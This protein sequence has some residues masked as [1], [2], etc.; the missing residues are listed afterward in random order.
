MEFTKSHGAGNDFVL[1][2][3]FDDRLGLL[4]PKLVA[5]LCD[6]HQG[7]GAD[8]LIRIAP[9]TTSDFFMDYYNADGG[10][11]EMCGNGIRCLAKFVSDR[12][13]ATGDRM[14]VDTRAGVKDLVLYRG[15][16]GLVDRVRV[17]MGAPILERDRIPVAG[18]GD[19]LHVMVEAGGERFEAACVSMGN[20]HAV[21]FVD[22]LQ[23][24]PVD[25]LG[26]AIETAPPFPAKTNVEFTEV[27]SPD[28]V[29]VRVWERGVGETR[30]LTGRTVA[31]HMPGGTLDIEWS[32]ETVFLTGPVVEAF[33]G[34]FDETAV[35]P[36]AV[37]R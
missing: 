33:R 13:L 6:R 15:A 11:A 35:L 16:D 32:D 36:S 37:R 8:G 17:D 26:P 19:P 7:V 34:T 31:V 30:G 20:P 29:R 1:I 23:G 5:A 2:E 25:R 28:E 14:R 21:V 18:S 4:D 27:L 3:D 12:R 24:V 22:R 10:V 9:S